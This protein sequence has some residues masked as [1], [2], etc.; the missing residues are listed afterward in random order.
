MKNYEL[1]VYSV[2]GIYK[3]TLSKLMNDITFSANINSFQWNLNLDLAYKID[4]LIWINHRDIIKV[5]CFTDKVWKI[6]YTWVIEEIEKKDSP[7]KEYITIKLNWLWVLLNEIIF[8]SLWSDIFWKN[9][10]P[11]LTIKN[12]IDCFNAEYYPWFSYWIIENFWSN[13]NINFENQSCFEAL[14]KTQE[15]TTFYF[16]INADWTID[17]KPKNTTPTH[18]ATLRKNINKIIENQINKEIYNSIKVKYGSNYT[19]YIEDNTSINTYWKKQKIITDSN[20]VDIGSATTFANSFLAKNKDYK[21]QV[22][23]EINDKFKKIENIKPWDTITVL[24]T[25][26]SI[27]NL[28]IKQIDY[29]PFFITL[30]LEYFIK[31]TDYLW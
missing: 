27:Q 20:I 2:Q 16:Y 25:P 4:K 1:K 8:K 14:V 3:K 9:Q 17:F 15:T 12:I 6:I 29:R 24:N 10:D 21:Q 5:Y 18:K 11:A 22:I 7:D 23:I 31:L 28:Q 13:I 19:S 30:T 26:L